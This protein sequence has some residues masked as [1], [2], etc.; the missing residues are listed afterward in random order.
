MPGRLAAMLEDR[1][2]EVV[3]VAGRLRVSPALNVLKTFA[4]GASWGGT[5]SLV[6]PMPVKAHRTVRRW[7]ADDLV[8]R[9]SVGLEDHQDLVDD[10]PSACA[11]SIP[12]GSDRVRLGGRSMVETQRSRVIN[13]KKRSSSLVSVPQERNECP[14]GGTEMAVSRVI[15]MQA[16]IRRRPFS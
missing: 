12:A 2:H 3:D 7:D 5:R 13:G 4:I 15:E 8:L 10:I 11:R 14:H 9:I 6:A 16:W 1:C